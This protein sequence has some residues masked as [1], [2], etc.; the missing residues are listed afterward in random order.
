MLDIG[1]QF[2]R[3]TN[4]QQV[5]PLDHVVAEGGSCIHLAGRI[6]SEE[7][8]F[9]AESV[10]LLQKLFRTHNAAAHRHFATRAL[11]RTSVVQTQGHH[12]VFQLHHGLLG[13]D[14]VLRPVANIHLHA[15][16]IAQALQLRKARFG[17][18][19]LSIAKLMSNSF[20]SLS[21]AGRE[22][23]ISTPMVFAN[24]KTFR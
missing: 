10:Q 14:L 2:L 8:R 21:I 5:G 17:S 24:S 18:P 6:Q 12:S 4:D 3:S 20:A 22:T 15:D 1:R 11:E 9:H 16:M 19:L 7:Q 13:I 23:I